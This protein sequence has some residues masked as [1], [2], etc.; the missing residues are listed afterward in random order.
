MGLLVGIKVMIPTFHGT[1]AL[2]K[3]YFEGGRSKVQCFAV[4]YVWMCRQRQTNFDL[5]LPREAAL[6]ADLM[7]NLRF[8]AFF[9]GGL[10]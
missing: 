3:I 6:A 4:G 2:S 10:R 8:Q 7:T 1:R 9:G 5:H